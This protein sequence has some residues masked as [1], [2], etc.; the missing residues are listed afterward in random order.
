MKDLLAAIAAVAISALAWA[1]WLAPVPA[2]GQI[3]I[4]PYRFS[5]GASAEIAATSTQTTSEATSGG[6]ATWAAM[7]I[8]SADASRV[9]VAV[10]WARSSGSLTVSSATI[11]GVSATIL[12]TDDVSGDTFTSVIMWAE[13]PT[14]TSADIAISCSARTSTNV[15]RVYRMVGCAATAIDTGAVNSAL[16][17]NDTLTTVSGGIVFGSGVNSQTGGSNATWSGGVTE[18]YEVDF[19]T[20]DTATAAFGAA[21]GASMTPQVVFGTGSGNAAAFV[22]FEPN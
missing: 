16:T 19:A 14:G 5:G 18:D 12:H 2:D 15:M 6:S 17:M 4:D 21:T 11:R 1:P 20:A 13:V 10:I 3:V 7:D 9:V 8:G 22:S